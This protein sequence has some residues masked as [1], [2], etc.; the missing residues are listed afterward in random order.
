M[1]ERSQGEEGR[2]VAKRNW[3]AVAQIVAANANPVIGVWFLG[4]EPLRP[5]FF[6][7]LDGLLAISGLG[8]VAAVVVSRGKQKNFGASGAR[9]WLIW[10]AVI[11]LIEVILVLPSVIAA[12]FV[13]SSLHR[14]VGEVMREV[15]NGAGPWLA[16]AVAVWSHTG[17]T[18]GELRW[19]ADLTLRETG[20][21]RAN[22]FI[23][24]TLVM[25]LL[26]FW[27]K[28]GQP[29]HW[30]LAA[31]VLLVACLFTYTQLNPEHYLRLTG[32]TSRRRP[33]KSS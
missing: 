15:F 14:D 17:Q 32:F 20:E 27:G 31:Y 26:I 12:L 3:L 5:I 1:S 8:V 21:A 29:P 7:W 25:G 30:A 16:L 22:L 18:I 33:G 2:A 19:K 6:Y 24:R 10:F 13:L 4:W 23:H 28:W 9:L 11:G